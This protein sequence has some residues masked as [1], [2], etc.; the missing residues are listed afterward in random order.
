MLTSNAAE[1]DLLERKR[2][3]WSRRSAVIA[4]SAR[5]AL[6]AQHV[7]QV[8]AVD[9]ELL[10]ECMRA[11]DFAEH[12]ADIGTEWSFDIHI[13]AA[14]ACQASRSASAVKVGR[15]RSM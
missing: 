15:S 4:A 14:A 9:G 6:L 13:G 8:G 10:E 11:N 1:I 12:V 3:G 7:V 5:R 2:A